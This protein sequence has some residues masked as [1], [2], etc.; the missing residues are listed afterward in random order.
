MVDIPRFISIFLVQTTPPGSLIRLWKN[1]DFVHVPKMPTLPQKYFPSWFCRGNVAEFTGL[2]MSYPP[3]SG[4]LFHILFSYWLTKFRGLNTGLQLV[5]HKMVSV[6]NM[7][8]NHKRELLYK[9][10]VSYLYNNINT[11]NDNQFTNSKYFLKCH[12]S[13]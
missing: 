12:L 1:Q 3:P 6:C 2:V 13:W 8:Y 11:F 4:N 10:H 9:T 7:L 5:N